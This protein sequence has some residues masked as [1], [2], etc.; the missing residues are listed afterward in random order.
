MGIKEYLPIENIWFFLLVIGMLIS[1]MTYTWQFRKS[2]GAKP[3]VYGQACKA[4]WLLFMVLT[5][6]GS[7]LSDKIFWFKLNL[8]AIAL[9]PYFWFT[10]IL[11]ISKQENKV[12]LFV[13]YG[14]LAIIG[15]LWAIILSDSWS[16]LLV[17]QI[18]LDDQ[19]LKVVL[20]PANLLLGINSYLICATTLGLSIRW[21]FI[22]AGLRRRQ[23]LWFTISGLFSF[24]GTVLDD[25]PRVEWIAPLPLGF[26]LAGVFITWGFYRWHVYSIFPLASKLSLRICLMVC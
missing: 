21:V 26:L 8:M 6:V 18:W 16:G 14:F 7:E 5:S 12:P 13:R 25:I 1:L 24:L 11:G 3:Q 10:F 4:A 2:P 20:G 19:T 15:C 22:T 9:S 17:K 23:A